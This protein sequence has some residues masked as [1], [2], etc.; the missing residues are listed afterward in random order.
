ML[1]GV[2]VFVGITLL[3]VEHIDFYGIDRATALPL[4]SVEMTT[5]SFFV[6]A[7]IWTCPEKVE[8]TN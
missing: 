1:L 3:R 6:A 4:V 5:R 8:S 7:P 2:L